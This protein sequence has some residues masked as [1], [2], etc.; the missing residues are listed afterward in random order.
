MQLTFPVTKEHR[1]LK[2]KAFNKVCF[3]TLITLKQNDTSW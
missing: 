1:K 2:S 3:I